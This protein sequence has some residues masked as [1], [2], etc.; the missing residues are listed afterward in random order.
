[1]SPVPHDEDEHT[2]TNRLITFK[3]LDG[4]EKTFLDN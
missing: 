1:M 3:D 2:I 4:E